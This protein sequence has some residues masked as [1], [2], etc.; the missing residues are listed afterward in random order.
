LD[1][2]PK[3]LFG[4][5]PSE[6]KLLLGLPSEL[7]DLG[8]NSLFGLDSSEPEPE[9]LLGALPAYE[10]F[11]PFLSKDE[12]PPDFLSRL[13]P[14]DGPFLSDLSDDFPS[15]RFGLSDP[16]R[17]LPELFLLLFSL[18]KNSVS[19]LYLLLFY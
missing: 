11:G 8:L 18:I 4:L 15:E 19:L 12:P 6:L 7:S 16:E 5:S 14:P 2:G 17:G 9:S 10:L 13:N 1:L 3:L